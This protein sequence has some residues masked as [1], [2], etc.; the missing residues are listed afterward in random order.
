MLPPSTSTSPPR[1]LSDRLNT[2]DTAFQE[3]GEYYHAMMNGSSASVKRQNLRMYRGL[4]RPMSTSTFPPNTPSRRLHQHFQ[5]TCPQDRPRSFYPQRCSCRPD[6]PLIHRNR[7]QRRS[8]SPMGTTCTGW[9]PK[10]QSRF[11]DYKLNTS[12]HSSLLWRLNR[13]RCRSLCMSRCSSP[14]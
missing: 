13:C 11:Q 7:I 1:N 10:S 3:S 5:N 12:R 14:Q 2:S 4:S 8:T 9:H 6:K